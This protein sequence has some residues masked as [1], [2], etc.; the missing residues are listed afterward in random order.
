MRILQVIPFFSPAYGGSAAATFNISRELA[1]RGHKVTIFASDYRLSEDWIRSLPQVKV[2]PFKTILGWTNSYLTPGLVGFARQMMKEFDLI[3]MHNYRSFQ[4]SIIHHYA[5]KFGVPYILQ[6]RG[7]LP[8]IMSKQAL[9]LV[10]DVISGYSVLRDSAK[11]IAL[12]TTEGKQYEAF[13]VPEDKIEI[14]PNGINLSEYFVLP[15]QGVFKKKFNIGKEKRIILH[16]GRIHKIKGIDFLIRSYAQLVRSKT[17]SNVILVIAGPD[18]GYLRDVENMTS[19]LGL[20]DKVLFTGPLYGKD[21]LEAYVDADVF[22][23]PS[24]YE[25]F[26]NVVLELYACS[27]PVIASRIDFLRELITHG[28]TGFLFEKG[29]IR[30]LTHYL[31]S[32]LDNPNEGKRMGSEGR[33]L[34][35]KQFSMERV[36]NKLEDLYE[37]VAGR[38]PGIS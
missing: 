35:E 23:L 11:V 3:H 14:I 22:V 38:S 33:K 17:Y 12:S 19:S 15:P 31:Q 20:Q 24:R 8:R 5:R 30:E 7:S 13:G 36:M 27:R 29:N 34:V 2:Y 25:A 16:L 32:I 1:K 37:G 6:A 4:N 21:K 9:K 18:D 28:K 10:Y 26:P